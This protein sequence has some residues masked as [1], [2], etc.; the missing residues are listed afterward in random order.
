ML[1]FIP[2]HPGMPDCVTYS[3]KVI[4]GG[5]TLE[6]NY[7]NLFLADN[8]K[9]NEIIFP[10]A[11]DGVNTRTWGGT[12]FIIRAG[13]GGSMNP[14]E[15]GVVSGWGG[16]RTTKQFAEKFPVSSDKVV[17][18]NEGKTAT[19]TKL[20]V[21]GAYQNWN[22]TNTQ[23][24]LSSPSNNKVYEGHVYFPEDN[25]PSFSQRYLLIICS[26]R[27]RQWWRWYTGGKRRYH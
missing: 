2:A 13:I 12:T 26:A 3:N 20:Y 24:S 6:S 7:Q 8:N 25:S 4:N 10:I 19:Y 21:P 16:T 15:S 23:T 27:W 18:P 14:V 5:Y 1:K 9:S 22:G 17:D 11:F